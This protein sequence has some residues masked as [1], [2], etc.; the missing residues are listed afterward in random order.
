MAIAQSLRSA[1]RHTSQ[2]L[3]PRTRVLD[4]QAGLTAMASSFGPGAATPTAANPWLDPQSSA[5]ATPLKQQMGVPF[6]AGGA[7]GNGAPPASPRRASLSHGLDRN[8]MMV[9]DMPVFSTGQ[10]ARPRLPPSRM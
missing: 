2:P 1:N 10:E 8:A 4:W 6:A 9:K 3:M 5:T 7:V